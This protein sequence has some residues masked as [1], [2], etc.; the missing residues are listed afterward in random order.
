MATD[1]FRARGRVGFPATTNAGEDRSIEALWIG[2]LLIGAIFLFASMTT[3]FNEAGLLTA[4]VGALWV[5][6]AS[7]WK[8]AFDR[9]R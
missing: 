7:L 9:R 8:F 2:F 3:K 6:A 4:G 5:I 1:P